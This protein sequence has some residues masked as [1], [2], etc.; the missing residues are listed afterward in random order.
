LSAGRLIGAGLA[1][2]AVNLVLGFTF[3]HLVGVEKIQ[4][5]LRAHNLRVIGEPSD[6]I[7]HTLVRLLLGV[8]ATL[9]FW[10]VS[11]RF[12]SPPVAAVVAGVFA[13]AFVYAYTAW[14]HFHIGLFPKSLAWMLASWGLFEMIATALAGGWIAT[15]RSFWR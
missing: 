9:L 12:T 2:G 14:G 13:W 11:A 5:A 8:G 15:G 6:A 4:S 10:A 1:A 3:A 7:P